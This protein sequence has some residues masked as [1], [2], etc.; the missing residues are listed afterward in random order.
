MCD[1]NSLWRGK[2]I[3]CRHTKKAMCVEYEGEY[4]WIPHSQL[5]DDSELWQQSVKGDEGTLVIPRWL[6]NEKGFL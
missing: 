3:C 1:W 4:T 2:A 6:A 5:H